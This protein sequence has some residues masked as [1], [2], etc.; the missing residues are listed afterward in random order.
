[1]FVS[2]L[3]PYARP[4]PRCASPVCAVVAETSGSIVVRA[5]QQQVFAAYDNIERMP[6]WLLMLESVKFLD[7]DERRSQ[8]SLNVP[9][10]VSQLA[11]KAGFGTLVQWEAVHEVDTPRRLQW[12]SVSGFE[13]E[14]VMTFEPVEGNDEATHVTLQMTYTLPKLAAPLV[15]NVLA[16]R[17]MRYTV[18]R[19]MERFRDKMEEEAGL[20]VEVG[21][22]AEEAEN[23]SAKP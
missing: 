16:R 11:R 15:E 3:S 8:W 6:E 12:N 5:S 9:R 20:I 22:E 2:A 10:A 13:N 14:G 17:F 4:M 18:R 23:A 1:M 19:T 21:E 7:K